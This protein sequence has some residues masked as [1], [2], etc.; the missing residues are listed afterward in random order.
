MKK[1][2]KILLP[3][4]PDS[5]YLRK[6][7]WHRLAL[8]I[9]FVI[10]IALLATSLWF[11]TAAVQSL[12]H[13]DMLSFTYDNPDFYNSITGMAIYNSQSEFTRM[14]KLLGK[15]DKMVGN[16]PG[17]VPDPHYNSY[18]GYLSKYYL[19]LALFTGIAA[20]VFALLL[21]IPSVMYR[22]ILYVATNNNWKGK[23]EKK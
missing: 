15:V 16:E 20:L 4:F 7:W 8:T 19:T 14:N 10:N 13:Q 23:N 9:F 22:I 21:F 2:R 1:L 17:F 5:A 12:R 6:Y 3:F 18:Q 11:G